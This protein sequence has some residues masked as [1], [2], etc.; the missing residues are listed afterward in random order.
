MKSKFILTISLSLSL[1]GYSQVGINTQNP[2]GSLHVDGKSTTS[3]TNPATGTPSATQLTDDFIIKNNGSVGIG[4]MPNDY[5]MLDINATD[6]GILIPR[7]NLTSST[8]D[9][10]GGD[11]STQPA[12]LMIYNTGTTFSKGYY[13]WN[14]TTWMSIDSTNSIA[15]SVTAITCSSAVLSPSSWKAGIPYEGNLKISYTGGNGGAY[16]AGSS[17]VVN[18]LTF[19]LRPGKLEYGA[20]ELVFS[21]SGTP[22]DASDMTLPVNTTLIPFLTTTQ[23]CTASILNQTTADI[24]QVAA[25]GNAIYDNVSNSYVFPLSTPDGK[26]R[27]RVRISTTSA[28]TA[29][30]SNV[31]IFNNTGS[32]KTLYWNY[33]SEY[34]NGQVDASGNALVAPEGI[35]GGAISGNSWANSGTGTSTTGYWGNEGIND[36]QAGGPEYRRYTWIDNS[37]DSKVAYTAYIM[38]GSPNAG[39]VIPNNTKIYIKIEQVTAQ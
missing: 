18:G 22:T 20:G 28:T 13:F 4:V 6:K 12:G 36:G 10:Q 29:G 24:K 32:A 2:Q 5:T 34:G 9:L 11:T 23:A 25:M 39:N 7:I 21:V 19:V 38:A 33:S 3:T 1:L 17:V 14:G 8:M 31:Q 30:S 37:T 35:W 27:V 26:Y 16:S 15:P